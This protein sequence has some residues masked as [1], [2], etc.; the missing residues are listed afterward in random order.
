M[1]RKIKTPCVGICSTTYG[2]EVCR[3]CK[4]FQHEVIQ[5]NS[6]SDQ[7]KEIVWNRLE[8]LKVQIMKTKFNIIDESKLKSSLDTYNINY[9]SAVDP[10]CWV[11]DLFKQ[12]SQSIKDFEEFG[13]KYLLEEK[14]SPEEIKKNLEEELFV[15]SEAH[16]QRYFKLEE[17][18]REKP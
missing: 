1:E 9:Y 8:A 18:F 5:W 12:A 13:L 17:H 4:R 16:Y 3:G 7:Q 15:L 10:F 2:D 6:Y 14:I 11:F